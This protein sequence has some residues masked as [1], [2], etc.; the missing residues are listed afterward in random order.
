[1]K[2]YDDP[3]EEVPMSMTEAALRAQEDKRKQKE[4]D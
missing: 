4:D 3:K 2:Q 1:V